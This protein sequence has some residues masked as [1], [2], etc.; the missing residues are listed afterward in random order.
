MIAKTSKIMMHGDWMSYI[1][2]YW[3]ANTIGCNVLAGYSM[4]AIEWSCIEMINS[5]FTI[6]LFWSIYFYRNTYQ[7]FIFNSPN[8]IIMYNTDG[9]GYCK[10][11]YHYTLNILRSSINDCTATSV[12]E[13]DGE[14]HIFRGLRCCIQHAKLF[15]VLCQL[16]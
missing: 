4:D 13:S 6:L 9:G 15:L 12:C 1:N 16:I 11:T 3:W 8:L 5:L 7:N 14:N 2:I 10:S